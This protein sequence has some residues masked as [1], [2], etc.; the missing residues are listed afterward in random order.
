M[1]KTFGTKIEMFD[2]LRPLYFLMFVVPMIQLR[3]QDFYAGCVAPNNR[4]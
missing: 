1:P 3:S 4:V 2:V